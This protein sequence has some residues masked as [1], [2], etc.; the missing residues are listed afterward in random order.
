MLTQ[1]LTE[2]L[3][4]FRCEVINSL[5]DPDIDLTEELKRQR[6][7]IN[8]ALSAILTAIRAEC[9]KYDKEWEDYPESQYEGLALYAQFT[10]LEEI[11][12]KDEYVKDLELLK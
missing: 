10:G 7:F 5:D 3:E 8:T 6:E 12:I 9:I 2:I 1:R 4:L 11:E